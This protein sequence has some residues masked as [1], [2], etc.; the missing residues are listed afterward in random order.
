MAA[1][2][3]HLGTSAD[4]ANKQ[5]PNDSTVRT[6]RLVNQPLEDTHQ[7]LVRSTIS[8]ANWAVAMAA[9]RRAAKSTIR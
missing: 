6:S 2:A 7:V 3:L 1:P 9:L 5:H 4:Q 8:A